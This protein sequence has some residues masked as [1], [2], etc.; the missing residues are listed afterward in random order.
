M[1]TRPP[2]PPRDHY[3]ELTDRILAALETGVKPWAKPWDDAAASGPSAPVN[4]VTGRLYRGVNTIILGMD[5]RA[6]ES[7]DPRWATFNQ[8]KGKGWNVRKGERAT[9]I[10]FYKALEIEGE[11]ADAPARRVPLLRAFPVF[12]ASQIEGV[13][14]RAKPTADEAP[15]IRPEAA[16]IILEGSQAAIRI[17]GPRAYYSPGTDHIQLPPHEAFSGPAAW[18]ATALHE[19]GHW[20]GHPSRLN[21]DLRGR[22]GSG[23]YAQEEL[24]AELSSV[25]VG[26]VLGIPADIPNHASYIANW[27]RALKDDKREIF[28]AAADAQRIADMELGFHPAFAASVQADSSHEDET[29]APE[30]GPPKVP[31]PAGP[32]RPGRAFHARRPAR[33]PAP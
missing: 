24:R 9:T 4:A 3:Q 22:F 11:T 23:A 26:G 27:I 13:P 28:R 33:T 21:R 20:T 15:W 19:L 10:F 16:Q 29:T 14:A 6:F 32:T 18:A 12:H 1:T 31:S 30:T 7:G 8:A 17:G 5:P 25:F 2:F